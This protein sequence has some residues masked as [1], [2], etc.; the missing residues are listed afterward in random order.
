LSYALEDEEEKNQEGIR[1]LKFGEFIW[2]LDL[3][4]SGGGVSAANLVGFFK[5][6]FHG[7]KKL[8][9]SISRK[10]ISLAEMYIPRHEVAWQLEGKPN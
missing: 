2:E 8:S 5:V 6:T 4:T 10:N 3:G 9:G 7:W 1:G